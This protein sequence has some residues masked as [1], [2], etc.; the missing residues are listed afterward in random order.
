MPRILLIE[1]DL[2]LRH[3]LAATLV[4]AGHAVVEAANGR[5]GMSLFH[6]EPVDLVI[7]DILMPEREGIETIATIHRERPEVPIIAISG[8]PTRSGVYLALAAKF[9]ASYTLAKPFSTEV[10]LRLIGE[11]LAGEAENPRSE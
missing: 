11:A 8:S 4:Q 6:T 3:V 1:D 2:E 7:T 5:E 9:G 10:L